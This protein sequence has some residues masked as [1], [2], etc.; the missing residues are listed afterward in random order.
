MMRADGDIENI[1]YIYTIIS[2]PSSCHFLQDSKRIFTSV[3]GASARPLHTHTPHHPFDRHIAWTPKE[4]KRHKM[5]EADINLNPLKCLLFCI[6]FKTCNPN[7]QRAGGSRT[8]G[9]V[10]VDACVEAPDSCLDW[11]YNNGKYAYLCTHT[12]IQKC[13]KQHIYID[14]HT[15]TA[16]LSK[17][18]SS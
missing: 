17:P 12:H 4:K 9:A 2:P 16:S 1:I 14:S 13:H 18:L 11:V 7:S 3:P 5:K 15:C 8:D 10:W 6:S